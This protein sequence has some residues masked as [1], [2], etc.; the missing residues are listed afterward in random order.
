MQRDVTS[1]PEPLA[2]A[3]AP[4]RVD[5]AGQRLTLFE[6]SGSLI[7]AMI[8]DI[9]AA[10]TRVWM[11]TYIFAA[12]AA[13]GAMADALAERARA[14]LDVRLMVDGWGSFNMPRAMLNRC[15]PRASRCTCFTISARRCAAR[16]SSCNS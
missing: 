15:A 2:S 14:G 4:V 9:A 1:S 13:G 10:R 8:A 11:E 6:E 3:A 12:D 16:S 7:A 5:V